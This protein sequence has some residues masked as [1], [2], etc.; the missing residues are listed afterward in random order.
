M[1]VGRQVRRNMGMIGKTVR[2]RAGPMKGYIGI[3]KDATDSTVKV[4]L[5]TMPKVRKNKL[6]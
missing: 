5:H 4:E 1:P 6:N 2:I 3:V